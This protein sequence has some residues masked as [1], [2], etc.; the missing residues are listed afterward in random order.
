M[1]KDVVTLSP[2][3]DVF[4][5][6]RTLIDRNISGAPVVDS[7]GQYKG[8]LSEKCCI[9]V[10]TL[11]AELAD[12]AGESG[13]AKERAPDFMI[14]KVI[15]FRPGD[16]AFDAIDQLLKHRISGAPVLDDDGRFLGVFSERY[17][18]SLL[19]RMA[20][21]GAPSTKVSA[22]MNTDM[23]RIIDEDTDLL[24][25]AHMFIDTYYR[26]LPVLR[27]GKL[28][29]Q[30]S[31]RDVLLAQQR[32]AP[33]LQRYREAL[34]ERSGEIDRSD[35]DDEVHGRLASG[36]VAAFMDRKAYTTGEETDLLGLAQIFLNTNYRR[37]PVLR[38]G[39]LVGQISRRDVLRAT[40]ELMSKAP[41]PERALL[42]LSAVVG[43]K[44]TPPVG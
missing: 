9:S 6:I 8:M 40:S 10:L 15:S 26:R 16:D 34:I 38:D 1:V 36:D 22:F 3:T 37:L 5:G 17:A 41:Q 12:E 23:G 13:P 43:R 33:V 31:R 44:E 30:I 21:E 14:R 25:V 39:K 35:G 4:A 24:H 18:M 7:D 29:G 27:D 11:A 2:E 42:Y 32:L 20:L 19:V 28:V